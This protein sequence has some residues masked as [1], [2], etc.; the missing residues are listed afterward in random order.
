ML[1]HALATHFHAFHGLQEIVQEDGANPGKG[2]TAVE[3]ALIFFAAPIGIFALI[4][5][6]VMSLTGEKKSKSSSL[7]YIE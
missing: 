2:L 4:S 6:I 5:G 1:V 3:T 7:T